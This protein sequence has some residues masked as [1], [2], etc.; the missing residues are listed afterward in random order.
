MKKKIFGFCLVFLFFGAGF[1]FSQTR[2]NC[3]QFICEGDD[4]TGYVKNVTVSESSGLTEIKFYLTD[5]EEL[6]VWWMDRDITSR[7]RAGNNFECLAQIWTRGDSASGYNSRYQG[8]STYV[9]YVPG[10]SYGVV[11]GG[12]ANGRGSVV[13]FLIRR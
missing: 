4:L 11:V 5:G 10:R 6:L 2:Y 13:S 8:L 7:A 12:S 1:A 3:Q 9:D